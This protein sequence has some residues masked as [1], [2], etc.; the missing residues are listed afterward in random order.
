MWWQRVI[1]WTTN[2]LIISII[3]L[4]FEVP[5]KYRLIII[6]LI[7]VY[8]IWRIYI[9]KED[10]MYKAREQLEIVISGKP[11]NQHKGKIKLKKFGGW[12]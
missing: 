6:G 4:L 8:F 10:L 11:F 5:T 3:I 2:I 7:V 1:N 9:N 12:K